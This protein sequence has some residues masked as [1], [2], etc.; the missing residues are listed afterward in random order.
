MP[1]GTERTQ[2]HIHRVT[3][4]NKSE[5]ADVLE[6]FGIIHFEGP[7][8]LRQLKH[9]SMR[10]LATGRG[11]G[12]GGQPGGEL[13]R[14][15]LGAGEKPRISWTH[16]LHVGQHQDCRTSGYLCFNATVNTITI[17]GCLERVTGPESFRATELSF[18]ATGSHHFRG[19]HHH[20][21]HHHR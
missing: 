10:R 12:G 4:S 16:L 8:S 7:P 13:G 19:Q 1:I 15:L 9:T 5:P 20:H 14:Q 3:S 21:H 2:V 6:T 11:G 18:F 17:S